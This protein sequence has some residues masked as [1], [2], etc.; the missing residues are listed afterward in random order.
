MD[1]GEE[2]VAK[3]RNLY[4]GRQHYITAS[5]VAT[6]DFMRNVLAMPVPKVLYWSSRSD[7]SAV[8]AEYIT[9]EKAPGVP[10]AT[11]WPNLDIFDRIKIAKVLAGYQKTLASTAFPAYGNL[12]YKSDLGVNFASTVYKSSTGFW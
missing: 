3:L 4:A 6:M 9:M 1:N 8:G 2:V 12:Y 7:D 11:V 10:L 5:E